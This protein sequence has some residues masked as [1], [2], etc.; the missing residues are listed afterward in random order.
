MG[1]IKLGIS[2]KSLGQPFR[3]SLPLAQK[4]GVASVELEATGE[5]A[6]KNLTQTGRREITH[7]LRSHDLTVSAITCPLR[8]GLDVAEN[9]EPRLEHI[10]E[11]MALAYDLGPRL[12]IMPVGKLPSPVVEKANGEPPVATGGILLST[13]H[14]SP[15]ALLKESLEALGKHG[16][17]TGV[18]IALEVGL[19]AS[20]EVNAYL[21]RYSAGSLGV[22]F[23]PANLLLNG[24]NPYDA[25]RTF[26][27]R[28]FVAHAQ[29]AR[30]ISPSKLTM[31]PLGH[32]DID[33][34][35][36]LAHFEEIDY[37]GHLTVLA[38]DRSEGAEG[39]AFLA[40]LV[41]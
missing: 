13:S 32:G 33:W 10:R 17:R 27:K 21:E 28:L 4:L 3:R 35:Q 23:N 6:P 8:R 15:E 22:D 36:I 38:D 24:F 20:A 12:V 25:I 37:R 29:D 14:A 9:L 18:N 7:L 1:R 40:R 11:V 16:D 26:G 30:R 19:D 5:L 2:L 31:V 39:V 41:R 34:L